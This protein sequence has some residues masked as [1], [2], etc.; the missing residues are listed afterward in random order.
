[1]SV[2]F[3]EG[4]EPCMQPH[5]QRR[6]TALGSSG[7]RPTAAWMSALRFAQQNPKTPQDPPALSN[8]QLP[9]NQSQKAPLGQVRLVMLDQPEEKPALGKKHLYLPREF[10]YL[11]RFDAGHLLGFHV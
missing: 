3:G 4:S 10:F 8:S 1:M 5:P 2:G 7:T 9:P 6:K 11:P